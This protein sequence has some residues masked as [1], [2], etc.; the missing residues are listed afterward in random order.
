MIQ[1]FRIFRD[2]E[3]DTLTIEES[4]VLDKVKRSIDYQDLNAE[5]FSI[6]CKEKYE[7]RTLKTAMSKDNHTIVSS[8]RTN[9]LYPIGSYAEVIADSITKLYESTNSQTVELIFDDQE[10]LR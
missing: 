2:D 7:S 3:N 1:R 9:N 10:L 6:V 5:D 4:A 8:I